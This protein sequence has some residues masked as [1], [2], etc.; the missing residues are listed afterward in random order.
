MGKGTT[1]P[2]YRNR[3]GQLVVRATHLA[4]TD[5]YQYVYVLRCGRCGHAYG[6]DEYDGPCVCV[7]T[8]RAVSRGSGYSSLWIYS[9]ATPSLGRRKQS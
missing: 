4:G 3:D 1:E 9:A 2:G 7:P 8:A 5:H 6:A